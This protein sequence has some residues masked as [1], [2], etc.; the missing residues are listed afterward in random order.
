MATPPGRFPNLQFILSC[1]TCDNQVAACS[2]NMERLK[3][4]TV[5]AL[6]LNMALH[7]P[8][9]SQLALP[10]AK[11]LRYGNF[12]SATI[13]TWAGWTRP[14]IL[15]PPCHATL[16]QC[17][18][19]RINRLIISTV[20]TSL[21]IHEMCMASPQSSLSASV[22]TSNFELAPALPFL[23]PSSDSCHSSRLC[24][25]CGP[26]TLPFNDKHIEYKVCQFDTSMAVR[27][28]PHR[29]FGDPGRVCL[30]LRVSAEARSFSLASGLTHGP[31]CL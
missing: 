8:C 12:S 19:A 23:F 14:S 5:I 26:R 7:L 15:R 16:R 20:T 2:Q 25:C 4:A 13:S 21:V 22:Y 17:H 24:A 11:R 3:Q 30:W 1:A 29:R 9:D 31:T 10:G 18:A 6:C 27:R 28:A